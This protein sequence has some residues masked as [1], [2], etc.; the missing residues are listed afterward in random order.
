MSLFGQS[1]IQTRGWCSGGLCQVREMSA[2]RTTNVRKTE[3]PAAKH[4]LHRAISAPDLPRARVDGHR[5]QPMPCCFLHSKIIK[6]SRG[7]RIIPPKKHPAIEA[8]APPRRCT[9]GTVS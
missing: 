8:P 1:I 6:R 9:V 3:Q 7:F 2:S 4:D 5:N